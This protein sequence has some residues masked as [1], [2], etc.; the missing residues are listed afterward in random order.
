MRNLFPG[1]YR[2]TDEEFLKLWSEAI[3][4]FDTN[5]LLNL[6]GYPEEVRNVFISV[7]AKLGIRIWVPYQVGLE[8][9]RNR[10]TRIKQSNKRVER[11]LKMI[12]DT[13]EQ[14]ASE[15]TS[16]EL[17]K[18]NIGIVDIQQRLTAVQATH[19]AL[20][21]AVQLA[22]DKL[23]PISLDDPIGEHICKLLDGR[24]GSPPSDQAALDAL[25]IDAQERFDKRIPPGFADIAG[26]GDE[27]FRDREVTYQRKFGDLILWRQI[28]AEAN[29]KKISAIVF[30]TGDKKND[31]WLLDE[32]KTLGPLP[33]LVQEITSKT[34][35]ELFW[36]YSSDEFL[37]NAEKHLKAT[38]VTPETIQQV[39]DLSIQNY[40]VVGTGMLSSGM[41]G[42]LSDLDQPQMGRGLL[43]WDDQSPPSAL[44]ARNKLFDVSFSGIDS[45][46]E[47][48]RKWLVNNNTSGTVIENRGFPD[49]IVDKE[50]TLS[51]YDVKVLKSFSPSTFPPTVV[52]SLLRGYFEVHE[53][54]LKDFS[55]ILVLPLN[56]LEYLDDDEWRDEVIRRGNNLIRKYPAHA[57]IFGVVINETFNPFLSI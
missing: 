26:K 5:V 17:E 27:T 23:P 2:P 14:L 6:Y 44:I 24:V 4:V 15:V 33:E 31:W 28:L 35:V 7:L 32:G 45:I 8:F 38:E 48:I 21:E 42:L 18:R 29:E 54:R 55:I 50:G 47:A 20:S 3:F 46:E 43:N 53:G 16:I 13:S 56:Y 40:K 49:F 34:P 1:Y 39:K 9:H 51:G 11:L 22:C 52:N 25:L 41:L 30:V 57:M 37:K 12:S 19:N 36:M 10:F